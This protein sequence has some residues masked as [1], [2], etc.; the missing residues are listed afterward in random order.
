MLC[1][2]EENDEV[3]S[4]PALYYHDSHCLASHIQDYQGDTTLIIMHVIS[5]RYHNYNIICWSHLSNLC[6]RKILYLFNRWH[7][8]IHLKFSYK[9]Q[10]RNSEFSV[11]IDIEIWIFL[12]STKSFFTSGSIPFSISATVAMATWT[13]PFS[14]T[15][16]VLNCGVG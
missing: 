2:G 4:Q 8:Y 16:V 7:L 12:K 5:M 10:Y 6:L 14:T 13:I 1:R 15:A 11:L 3:I 9:T